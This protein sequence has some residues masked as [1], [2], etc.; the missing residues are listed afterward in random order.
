MYVGYDPRSDV[1]DWV[2]IASPRVSKL[3][4]ARARPIVPGTVYVYDKGYLDLAGGTP[5]MRPVPPSS[6][7]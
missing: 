5:S 1:V 3:T 6:P 2:E 7:G 4:I